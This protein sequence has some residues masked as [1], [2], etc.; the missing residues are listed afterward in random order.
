MQIE[1]SMENLGM[2]I[3][4]NLVTKVIQLFET[5]NV[6]FGVMLVGFTTSAKTTCYRVL[7]HAMTELRKVGHKDQRFQEVRTH[8][9]NPKSI[10]MGELYGEVN[11]FT[12]EWQD[13]LGSKIMR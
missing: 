10:T 7:Q 12:Q 8:V 1:K 9:I 2:Q 3:V 6:R 11:V 13:G 4:P 5:F